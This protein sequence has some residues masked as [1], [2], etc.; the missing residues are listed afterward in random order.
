[1]GEDCRS[2][3]CRG[4]RCWGC[5]RPERRRHRF[6]SGDGSC[7]GDDYDGRSDDVNVNDLDYLV[8]VDD[9]DDHCGSDNDEGAYDNSGADYDNSGADY[10]DVDDHCGS[11]ND[12]GAY[13]NSGADY[14]DSSCINADDHS[15]AR[16]ADNCCSS[17]G[18]A[19]ESW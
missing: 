19:V 13:D 8:D 9:V 6:G 7:G 11:D 10:D 14:D 4:G 1:V 5:G 15:C 18:A 2:C 16:G 3:C 17:A 12:E